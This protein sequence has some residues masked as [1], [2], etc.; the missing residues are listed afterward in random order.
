MPAPELIDLLEH[1]EL[2]IKGR[3]PW[4][5]NG[6]FLVDLCHEGSTGLGVYKP[7][8]GERPLWD[9]PGGLYQREVAAYRLSEALGWG[10]IPETVLRDDDAPLGVGSVQRFVEADFEQHYFTLY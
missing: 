8:R 4:S 9:F 3:M 10:V 2:A 1:G 6:T 7:L 5:S